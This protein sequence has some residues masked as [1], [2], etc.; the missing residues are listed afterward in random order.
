MSGSSIMPPTLTKMVYLTLRGMGIT[1]RI[2]SINTSHD[3]KIVEVHPGA[4]IGTRIGSSGLPHVLQ[5]KKDR[6][7]RLEIFTWF[8]KI[9]LKNLPEEITE[10]THMMDAT[11]AALAAWHWAD[12]TKQP[13]WH[14]KTI[15]SQ[16]PFEFCC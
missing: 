8:K 10:S 3:I 12:P 16:H 13:T 1:R 5:Y 14:W 2:N 11:A 9:G 15:S 4:A 7:S 6:K